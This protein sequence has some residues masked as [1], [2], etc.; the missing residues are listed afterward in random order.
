MVLL[1]RAVD[2]GRTL[3]DP[4]LYSGPADLLHDADEEEEDIED[5]EVA[6]CPPGNMYA[7][8]SRLLTRPK[9]TPN[10]IALKQELPQNRIDWFGMLE[11][12]WEK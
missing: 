5:D 12:R 7:A 11:R 4:I 2:E 3:T 1:E 10:K 9:S 6:T 8:D